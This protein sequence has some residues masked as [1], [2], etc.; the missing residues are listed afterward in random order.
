MPR[1]IVARRGRGGLGHGGVGRDGAG[2]H[3]V[4]A[5]RWRPS[6]ESFRPVEEV[7][8][9]RNGNEGRRTIIKRRV[10][11]E[12]D[13]VHGLEGQNVKVESRCHPAA[14]LPK[15]AVRICCL[16]RDPTSATQTIQQ[17]SRAN[18]LVPLF[19]PWHL[20]LPGRPADY[21]P[22]ALPREQRDAETAARVARS[23]GLQVSVS[24]L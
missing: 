4:C 18:W 7:G 12:D 24:W 13:H 20:P 2:N 3:R 22:S 17:E 9:T 8:H 23:P 11:V 21:P 15:L 14:N 19:S 10:G 1:S 5:G 16:P 6:S